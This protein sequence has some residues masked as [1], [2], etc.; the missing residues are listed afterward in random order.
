MYRDGGGLRHR[1]YRD[2]GHI[3]EIKGAQKTIKRD[4]KSEKKWTYAMSV[5][6]VALR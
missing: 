6:P 1:V 5:G 3:G 4:K 2:I